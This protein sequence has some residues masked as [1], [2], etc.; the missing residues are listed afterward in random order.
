M[1]LIKIFRRMLVG[2]LVL[3]PAFMFSACDIT[4]PIDGIKLMLNLKERNT[5]VS[6]VVQDAATGDVIGFEND[7]LTLDA[8]FSG[9]DGLV[10]INMINE[11]VTALRDLE[12]G[13]FNF[14]IRDEIEPSPENPVIFTLNVT[15]DGYLPESQLVVIDGNGENSIDISMVRISDPPEDVVIR[16][17]V[18]I[19]ATSPEGITLEP[20]TFSSSD[21]ENNARQQAGAGTLSDNLPPNPPI[22][23]I[24]PSVRF[25]ISEG[26]EISDEDGNP[27]QGGLRATFIYYGP[28]NMVF[29]RFGEANRGGNFDQTLFDYRGVVQASIEDENGRKAVL[30]DP[31]LELT[32]T[33]PASSFDTEE[34]E[35]WAGNQPRPDSWTFSQT[36]SITELEDAFGRNFNQSVMTL[37]TMPLMSM[38]GNGIPAC[39][40]G[41][42]VKFTG[43]KLRLQGD[44][45]RTDNQ[46]YVTSYRTSTRIVD[47]EREIE[48][49]F[50]Q[51]P[52]NVPVRGI[53]QN[54][55][56][57]QIDE[58]EIADLC[59]QTELQVPISS[60]EFDLEFIAEGRCAD[61]DEVVYATIPAQIRS[62]IGNR[63]R[64]AGTI[65]S[66]VLEVTLPEPDLYSI[67]INYDGRFYQYDIDLNNA[68]AGQTTVVEEIFD[69]P[70][71]ICDDV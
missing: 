50:Q 16:Q 64:P 70:D 57:T 66:G 20:I 15:A 25:F 39:L 36:V 59:A 38:I 31:P 58:F 60:P 49:R 2:V 21:D 4:N 5:T 47:G 14:A 61:R 19:G 34:F 69:I 43:T 30:F 52:R 67:G 12:N 17:N 27:L 35:S 37:G 42:T 23:I 44:L 41:A 62:S 71:N 33:Y 10:I 3:I 55:N 32:M 7:D 46:R 18:P 63:W 29:P 56:Y 6:V 51:V 9:I 54:M 8:T 24:T 1:N 28:N 65:L 13:L 53:V 68:V 40:S 11:E 48:T 26:T 22:S 45:F